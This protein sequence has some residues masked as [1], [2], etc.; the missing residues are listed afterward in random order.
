VSGSIVVGVIGTILIVISTGLRS[1]PYNNYS[2]L[3]DA[4]VHGR[5]WIDWPGPAIDA[6][7]YHGRYYVIEAPAPALFLVPAALFFGSHANQ[8]LLAAL[9]GGISVG[10]TW[11]IATRLGLRGNARLLLTAF[12]MVGTDVWWCAMYGDVWF[13]AHSS[14]VCFTTLALVELLGKRRGWLVALFGALAFESRF[15]MV[16]ALPVYAYLL[17]RDRNPAEIRRSLLAFGGTLVP[18]VLAWI[19]YNELRWGTVQD[20]GYTTWYHQDDVGDADGPPFKLKYLPYQLWS[21]FI[22]TPV[23]VPRYPWVGTT[24][25][26]IALTW[27]SPALVIALFARKP[28]G[29][30]IAMWCATLLILGPLLIYYVNGATQLG[31]RHALDFEPFLIVLMAIALRDREDLVFRGVSTVLL[32]YS[33]IVGFWGLWLWR[34]FFR[35]T[36]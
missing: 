19:G 26:G 8:T 24:V 17:V 25:S 12:F 6:L 13:V 27:T 29:L 30:V 10:A 35:P 15:D 22:Q 32:W 11:E 31:M 28:R 33:I 3:A 5:L 14:A 23:F 16:L 2:L 36:Y 9:L 21:F 34:T 1:T 20:I 4:I 7:Q 18:F